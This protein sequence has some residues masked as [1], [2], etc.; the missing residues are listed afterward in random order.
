MHWICDD[1][2][3]WLSALPDEPLRV[4]YLDAHPVDYWILHIN[5]QYLVLEGLLPQHLE[6][7]LAGPF[8]SL[9][10][11]KLAYLMLS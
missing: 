8:E 2:I 10:A 6:K 9:E 5:D 4:W 11:A 3:W 7:P 1:I